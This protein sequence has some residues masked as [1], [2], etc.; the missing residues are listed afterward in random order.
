MCSCRSSEPNR[1]DACIA[2]W[3]SRS[4][5]PLPAGGWYQGTAVDRSRLMI[6]AVPR[7]GVT[8]GGA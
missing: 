4:G 1:R 2:G 7:P 3:S 6:Y 5:S 8:L